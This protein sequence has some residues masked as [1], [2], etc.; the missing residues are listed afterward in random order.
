MKKAATLVYNT[1]PGSRLFVAPKKKYSE[2]SLEDSKQYIAL[3]RDFL[4][5]K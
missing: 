4:S 3:V 2:L 1:I 5:T